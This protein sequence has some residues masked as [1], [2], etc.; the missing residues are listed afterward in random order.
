MRIGSR[1]LG[2]VTVL[3]SACAGPPRTGINAY[4]PSTTLSCVPYARA[5]SG[6]QLS[7]DA[8]T[9]WGQAAGRYARSTA[10][11][12]GAVLVLRRY[13]SM[14]EGHVA[15]VTDVLSRREIAVT[16]ANWLPG[17]IEYGQP[18]FDVSPLNDWTL[19]RV[20]YPPARALGVTAYPADGFILPRRPSPADLARLE[21]MLA[22]R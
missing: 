19:V 2:F 11:A 14:D 5:V 3:L 22:A 20:W 10:P 9:W 18:V 6:I 8:W 4:G 13:G 1:M 16:Q 15:V 17:R 12:R 7:G 21:T